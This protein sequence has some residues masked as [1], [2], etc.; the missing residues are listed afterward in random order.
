MANIYL[1]ANIDDDE[2]TV[3]Q[4]EVKTAIEIAKY[5]HARF[6]NNQTA[7]AK[8][9]GLSQGEISALLSANL[10]RFSLERL[11][12][13]ARRAGLHLVLDMGES[14]HTA[15][16][17]RP[18]RSEISTKRAPVAPLQEFLVYE[19]VVEPTL[20]QGETDRAVKWLF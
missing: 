7:A 18:L 14:A 19:A 20:A 10:K 12:K 4:L 17:Q 13:I 6:P 5:I 16:V 3:L 11:I 2:A 15:S 8:S 9:L 1:S